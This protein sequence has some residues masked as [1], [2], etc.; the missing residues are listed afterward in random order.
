VNFKV[1]E[2]Y[3]PMNIYEFKVLPSDERRLH[4]FNSGY[5]EDVI[6]GNPNSM[7]ACTIYTLPYWL[8]VY[9]RLLPLQE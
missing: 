6:G 1:S 9:H 3:D 8:G 4:K 7:E 2:D 5:F